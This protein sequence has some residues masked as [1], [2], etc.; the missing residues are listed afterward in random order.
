MILV[1][2]GSTHFDELIEQVDAL[3]KS[4]PSLRD[5]LVCQ[6]GNG[7]YVPENCTYF[8]YSDDFADIL[9]RAD[10]VITHGGT[11]VLNCIKI[12]KRFIGVANT[13][14]ADDHQSKMLR[15]CAKYVDFPWTRDPGEVGE[16]FARLGSYTFSR[17]PIL[18]KSL[19]EAIIQ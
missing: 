5:Q 10:I 17:H 14:L 13:S 2:V 6:I 18:D 11:T 9:D 12:G 16:L 15:Q 7:T 19:V 1:T 3:A 4:Q 8:R